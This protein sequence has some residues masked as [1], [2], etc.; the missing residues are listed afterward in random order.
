MLSGDNGLQPM[1]RKIAGSGISTID[2]FTA[3]RQGAQGRVGQRHR[4]VAGMILVEAGAQTHQ[5][6]P[7]IRD[8]F[9]RRFDL[10]G[11]ALPPLP[12]YI[13]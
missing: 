3:G 13:Y 5:L 11:S 9:V 12:K 6:G 8:R 1:P 7:G 4:L 10:G 2:S